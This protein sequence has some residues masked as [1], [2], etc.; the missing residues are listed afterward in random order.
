MT[1]KVYKDIHTKFSE[2]RCSMARL[3]TSTQTLMQNL[4]AD[5]AAYADTNAN[6][7]TNADA[8]A[9]AWVSSIRHNSTSFRGGT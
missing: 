2:A 4:N 9:N 7:N 6:A 3:S 1:L 5:V 8:N